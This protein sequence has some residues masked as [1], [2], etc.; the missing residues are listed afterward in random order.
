MQ[1]VINFSGGKTSA[2]MTIQEYK[3]GDLVI[4]CDTGREHPKTYKFIND[5]EAHEN[6]PIIR[7]KY[8]NADN[9]FKYLLEKKKY[10]V[11]PNRVK[12][13][14]TDELKI[15]TCK[16]YL[17]SIGILTF[18]N[19]IGFRSDEPLRVKRRVQKFK[20]V[21]DK[22]P[23]YEKGITKEM[24]NDYW[25]SKPYN[26]EIPSILGNCTLCFMKGKNAIINILR[27]FPE[28]AEEWIKD[29]DEAQKNGKFGGHTYFPD[30]TYRD[31]L[32]IAQNNLFK[33]IDLYQLSPAFN[34]ACTT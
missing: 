3:E 25:S 18:E 13:F 8:G 16:R 11:I 5:F 21:I 30:I 10:K 17:K 23:L 2:Y 28:L 24:I 26:L 9:P 20:K 7:L 31:M 33:E 14:C 12:R 22:F 1:R 27:E 15:K 29:E 19:F 34:C 6:I 32:A 4:F